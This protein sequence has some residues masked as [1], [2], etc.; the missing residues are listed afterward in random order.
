MH[1]VIIP[2]INEPLLGWTV[3]NVKRVSPDAEIIVMEDKKHEGVG[4]MRHRGIKK[5]KHDT[6]II[7]DGHMDFAKNCFKLLDSHVKKNPKSIACPECRGLD[8]DLKPKQMNRFGA[9]LYEVQPGGTTHKPNVFVSKWRKS[10]SKKTHSVPSVL[11]A[12]YAFSKDWYMDGLGGV[13]KHH[14]GWGKSE[15]MLCLMN[16]YMGGDSVCVASTY[17]AHLFRKGRVIENHGFLK[18]N[19]ML[20]LHGFVPEKRRDELLNT[21]CPVNRTPDYGIKTL[22]HE[23]CIADIRQWISDKAVKTYADLQKI[24]K[25]VPGTTNYGANEQPRACPKC[26]GIAS[27]VIKTYSPARRKRTCLSC[28]G[29]YVTFTATP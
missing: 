24:M 10:E 17:A 14:R 26:K 6:V 2:A 25:Q 15:Q 21:F 8:K 3:D 22:K 28:G 5:A 23:S 19:T 18:R 20:L 9:D 12:C 11:G 29:Q 7:I 1:S 4:Q 27:R 13:W 16:H